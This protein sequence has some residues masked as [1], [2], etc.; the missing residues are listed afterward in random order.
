MIV[1]IGMDMVEIERVEKACRRGAFLRR[2][3]TEAEQELIGDCFRIAAGNFAVKEAVAKVFGT[4]FSKRCMPREIEVL[5]D[6][7][8]KPYVSLFGKTLETMK[9]LSIDQIHVSISNT[10]EL[11]CAYAVGES[12][13]EICSK[14]KRNETD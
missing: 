9:E 3:Y 1:G 14:C 8:G 12:K 13:S 11:A 6:S 10:K 2:I 5:R 4:G 7:F